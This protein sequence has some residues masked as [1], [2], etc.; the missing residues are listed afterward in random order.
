M[1]KKCLIC[2]K[3]FEASLK[4]K[5][6]S[7][8]CYGVSKKGHIPSAETRAKLSASHKGLNTWAKGC[9]R[10][11]RTEEH[12]RKLSESQIGKV[13]SIESRLKMS[14]AKK[15]IVSPNKGKTYAYKPRPLM[16]GKTPWHKGK[17]IPR[18]MIEAGYGRWKGGISSV[19]GYHYPWQHAYRARKK[20]AIGMFTSDEWQ[21]LKLFY[22]H[23]CLCC[24]QQ[25]PFIKL[26]ADHVIPLA[27]GGSN[28]ISNIQPLCIS[29]NSKKNARAWDFR[30]LD[31]Q[32]T[33]E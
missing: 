24:K 26:A 33:Y 7:M 9:K 15:G 23:M 3:E 12:R 10:P 32:N 16:K 28:Y 17:K 4:A 29:C 31:K 1:F 20:G 2:S 6:C 27:R 22:N 21:S 14:K 11:P 30:L 13:V 25:E 5:Y 8:P 18:E 19:K